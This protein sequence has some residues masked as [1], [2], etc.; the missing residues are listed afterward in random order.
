MSFMYMIDDINRN[1]EII[2][3]SINWAVKYK[4]DSFPYEVFK[5]YRRKLKRI[6]NA[7]SENCSAAAYGETQV[8]KS[9]L[10]S[11]LLSTPSNP[12]VIINKEQGQEKKYSFIDEINPS[13]GNNTR[14]ESTGVITRFTIRH[15][16]ERMADYVKITNLSIVDIILLLTDSYYNDVKINTES[17]LITT[18]ID[19]KL[20]QM[21]DLW[22]NKENEHNFISEDDI[23]DICDYINDVI[24]NNAQKSN[25]PML[26]AVLVFVLIGG[27]YYWDTF[28]LLLT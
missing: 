22:L 10:M 12:F 7:I 23:K 18:Q 25:V 17:S 20:N 9:Y 6:G 13:G 19:E 24:G 16:N 28:F 4:K 21:S 1:L 3:K 15:S 14:Q 8:G 11:S 27:F 5:N 26:I 2:E